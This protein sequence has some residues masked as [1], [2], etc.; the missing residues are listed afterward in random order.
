MNEFSRRSIIEN[1]AD[2]IR[3]EISILE[4]QG[5]DTTHLRQSLYETLRLMPKP[6]KWIDRYYYRWIDND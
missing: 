4:G 6:K 5:K 1:L 2:H 3:A